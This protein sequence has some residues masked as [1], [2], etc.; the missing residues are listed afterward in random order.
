MSGESFL[1]WYFDSKA[2]V[3]SVSPSSP[4]LKK[5]CCSNASFKISLRW[6]FYIINLVEMQS[7]GMRSWYIEDRYNHVTLVEIER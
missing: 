7:T 5:G 4:A 1:Q 3:S 2:D 6:S